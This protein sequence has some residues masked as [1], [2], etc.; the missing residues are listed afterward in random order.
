MSSPLTKTNPELALIDGD[1]LTYRIGFAYEK[2]HINLCL[3]NVD[4]TIDTILRNLGC[5]KYMVH[6]TANNRSNFRFAI[7]EDYKANRKAP[8]PTH[9]EDIRRF[10][11]DKH[12]AQVAEG[13]EA[14]DTIG[15]AH[16]SSGGNSVVCS[17]DKDFRQIPGWNFHFVRRELDWISRDEAESFFWQ[18]VITGDRID[19]IHGVKGYGPKKA[20]AWVEDCSTTRDYL[21]A[22][23]RLYL[24][25]FGEVG[26]N[27]KLVENI[28]LLRIK[29]S[30]DEPLVTL[31]DIEASLNGTSHPFLNPSESPSNTKKRK[32]RS[33]NPKR[34][35]PT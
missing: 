31:E 17:I 26:G 11:I 33:S 14:D 25:H 19:N 28:N 32:S 34:S 21:G 27:L 15:I 8:K 20:A 10:L 35:V 18:Q 24:E 7:R 29:Q 13:Q 6:L 22:V 4:R 1:I 9:Y 30:E 2:E 3:W 23:R 5:G 12:N 16:A